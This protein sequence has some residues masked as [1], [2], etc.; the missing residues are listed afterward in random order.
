MKLWGHGDKEELLGKPYWVLLDV[1]SEEVIQNIAESVV[2]TGAWEGELVGKSRDGRDVHLHVLT[3]IVKD[4][5]GSPI[6][7]VSAFID[8]TERKRIEAEIAD[9]TRELETLFNIGVTVSQTLNLEELL[10]S[11]LGR[12][13]KVM[14]MEMGGIY[15]IDS[16]TGSWF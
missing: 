11:V 9:Y 10:K 1:E 3:G 15:L 5:H 13:L 12:I 14:G 6:Q 7:T 2:K 16:A 4:E 8:I